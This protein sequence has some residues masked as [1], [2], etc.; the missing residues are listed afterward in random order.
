MMLILPFYLQKELTPPQQASADIKKASHKAYNNA[1]QYKEYQILED[2]WENCM[3]SYLTVRKLLG[4]PNTCKLLN[5]CNP[6]T[7]KKSIILFTLEWRKNNPPPPKQVSKSA[8]VASSSN[9]NVKRRHK[10]QKG[11]REGTSSKALHP[12][13]QDSKD[14]ARY[15]RKCISDGQNHDGITEEGGSQIKIPEMISDIFDSIPDLYEAINDVKK[16]LSDKNETICNNIKTNNLSLCQID[17]TLMCFEKVLRTI[18]TSNNDDSSGNKINDQSS[19]IKELTDKYS[20]FNIDDMIE[21]KIKH[22]I[23]I[24]KT[25]NKKVLE[26]IS[27][28]FTEVNT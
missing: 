10:L 16:H 3:N 2:L 17:E 26:E 27:N 15:H 8:P 28:S 12:R 11:Q 4:H 21:T 25:D 18:K 5:G 6:L 22:A 13:I 19:I 23:K 1:P 20:K 24:I 14:P 7:E 9:S